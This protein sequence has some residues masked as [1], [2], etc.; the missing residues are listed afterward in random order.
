MNVTIPESSK[1][2]IMDALRATVVERKKRFEQEHQHKTSRAT[3]HDFAIPQLE[4]MI[5][6]IR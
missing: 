4:D 6:Q 2:L 1:Y 5:E 3:P